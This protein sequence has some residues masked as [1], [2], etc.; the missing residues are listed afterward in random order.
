MIRI[1]IV[2]SDNSHAEVFSQMLNI[3]DP[4]TGEFA[5][6]DAR[7]TAIFGLDQ[8]RTE[9][10]AA[11]GKIEHIVADPSEMIGM[12][13]AV[14]VVFRH[15]GLHA[16]Y[17]LPFV[18][19]GIPTWIDKPFC[20]SEEDAKAVI[21][22]SKKHHTLI[23]GG[24]TC[25]YTYDILLAKDAVSGQRRIGKFRTGVI[26]FPAE[27]DSE[28]GGLYFYGGHLSEMTLQAFGWDMRRVTARE[29]NGVVTVI[30]EYD[31]YPVT[32]NFIP[33]NN[34]YYAVLY[35][36]NGV[37]TREIDI[38]TCYEGGFAHFYEMLKTE[39]MPESYERL[40]KPVALLN[41]I[42][43]SYKTGETVT[44]HELGETK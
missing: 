33:N 36:D 2:G 23:T 41:A 5:Y 39:K 18:E 12:V 24:S 34:V 32:M 7:V 38:S 44:I 11:D 8:K 10:V 21:E 16:K 9:Q 6:P 20:I 22:A 28:Y 40:F 35:G 1:G 19:A 14:M 4:V 3:P 15:G 42:E 37:I 29:N 30:G 25:K 17:A 31:E 43:K 27:L 26:N 13:D